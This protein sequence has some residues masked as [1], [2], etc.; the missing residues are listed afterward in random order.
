MRQSDTIH[1]KPYTLLCVTSGKH[2][3][4]YQN[5]RRGVYEERWL[6]ELRIVF[7]LFSIYHRI[8]SKNLIDVKAI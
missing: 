5:F 6:N 4:Y 2:L 3:E 8:R 1:I 7:T